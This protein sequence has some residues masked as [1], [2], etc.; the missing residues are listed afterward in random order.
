MEQKNIIDTEGYERL[1]LEIE[2]LK[3]NLMGS[4]EKKGEL[5]S[6]GIRDRVFF[7]EIDRDERIIKSQLDTYYNFLSDV[8]VVGRTNDD[9]IIDFDDIVTVN[10]IFDKDDEETFTFKLVG[11]VE[12]SDSSSQISV[13]SPLGK[14]VYHRRV[15]ELVNYAVDGMMVN[16][17][18]LS[19]SGKVNK[20]KK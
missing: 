4:K 17:E 14:S 19:K 12:L 16:V 2:N 5:Y 20:V 3:Y 1:K 18:I 7:D 11:F 10:M 8:M 9:E 13:N 15:G 6:L